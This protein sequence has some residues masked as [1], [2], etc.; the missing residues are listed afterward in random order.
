MDEE[1]ENR[2]KKVKKKNMV[3]FR[4]CIKEKNLLNDFTY[5]EKLEPE[6]QLKIIK[7][8]FLLIKL[9]NTSRFISKL[10]DISSLTGTG[11][12]PEYLIALS[13]IGNPGLG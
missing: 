11:L 12:A 2:E 9:S 13:Y 5:F 10:L 8:V 1:K 4:K 3:E 6:S 7:E